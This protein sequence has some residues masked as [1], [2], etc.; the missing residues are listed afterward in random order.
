MGDH[1]KEV[2]DVRTGDRFAIMACTDAA[3]EGIAVAYV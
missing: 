1:V 3:A 2:L